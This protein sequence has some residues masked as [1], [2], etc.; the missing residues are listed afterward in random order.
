MT[1]VFE[2][3]VASDRPSA[4]RVRVP[5]RARTYVHPLGH[6][7]PQLRG[8]RVRP[9]RP[10][11]RSSAPRDVQTQ[12]RTRFASH[13]S[14]C[15]VNYR[16]DSRR[17]TRG[18]ERSDPKSASRPIDA[19]E[20][21][22]FGAAATTSGPSRSASFVARRGDDAR[23]HIP[24]SGNRFLN[25]TKARLESR[26]PV[27]FAEFS[28]RRVN[29]GERLQGASLIARTVTVEHHGG[30]HADA[31]RADDRTCGLS[32]RRA[33]R[34]VAGTARSRPAFGAR[35]EA[36]AA[37]SF[38]FPVLRSASSIS[39]DAPSPSPPATPNRAPA[40]GHG[41]QP[42]QGPADFQHQRVHGG[43]GLHPNHPGTS[44]RRTLSPQIRP[45]KAP[46][47]FRFRISADHDD[48]RSRRAREAWTS[49]C[50]TTR[51]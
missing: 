29:S 51:A 31:Q 47:P 16:R 38:S 4:S 7:E 6:A 23:A 17:G 8:H 49:S 34:F 36:R 30:P 1:P 9:P 42:R 24:S 37:R 45:P 43:G 25:Q 10:V 39:A 15:R 5:G 2:A 26:L 12:Q 21:G 11:S 20:F 22:R 18:R 33:A 41:H 40:R 48:L 44:P 3:G 27:C 35:A 14:A 32:S 28:N 50:T 13:T 46:A 19:T